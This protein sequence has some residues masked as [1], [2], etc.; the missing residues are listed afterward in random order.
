MTEDGFMG[1]PWQM[2]WTLKA[3]AA[4]DALPE[5]VR[6]MIDAA[7]AEL[8]TATD[9]YFRG[10]EAD[11]DLPSGMKVAPVQSSKPKGARVLLFD[12][13]H[14]WMTYTFVRRTEDP[15]IV[16]EEVFWQ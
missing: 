10:V 4:R 15:Q 2:D 3:Q 9:P 13:G 5:D 8:V 14:G 12:G 7:R 1:P 11:R 16:V 6:K